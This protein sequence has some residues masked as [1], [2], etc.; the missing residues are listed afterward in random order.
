MIADQELIIA[1]SNSQ[2]KCKIY[3]FSLL[4]KKANIIKNN[5][6]N[7]IEIRVIQASFNIFPSLSLPLERTHSFCM[8]FICLSIFSKLTV[9]S[10]LDNL[11]ISILSS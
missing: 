1:E 9:L 6:V 5:E 8:S 2:F 7:N 4:S 3:I 10:F 11:S